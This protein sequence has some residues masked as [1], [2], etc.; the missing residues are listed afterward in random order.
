MNVLLNDP[1]REERE[2]GTNFTPID[3][4]ARNADIISFHTPL[5]CA[6]KYKTRQLFD[7]AFAGKLKAGTVII[8]SSRGEVID[9]DALK[10]AIA[11]KQVGA[12][13]LDVWENEPDIDKDLLPLIDIATP[14]I[15]GYSTDGKA[16]ATEMVVQ[17]VSQFFALPLNGWTI[18]E[19]PTV[20]N[21]CI[22]VNTKSDNF[23]QLLQNITPLSYD[24]LTDD[25]LLRT[26]PCLFEQVR[27]NYRV[28]REF[29]SYSLIF[30]KASYIDKKTISTLNYLGY[31][32]L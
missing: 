19:L 9:G 3:T 23:Q 4:I 32:I 10:R 25:S 21:T 8:N 20:K 27:K 16:K 7:D 6:G 12:V 1:P 14:H 18:G 30:D 26:N 31:N 15:A 28:R 17:A 24:I 11:C 22:K 2:R 29:S 13:V 5:I